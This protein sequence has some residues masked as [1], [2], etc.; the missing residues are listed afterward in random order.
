MSKIGILVVDDEPSL[1][2]FLSILLEKDGYAVFTAA[3]GAEALAVLRSEVID[4]VITDIQMDGMSGLEL[5]S[6]IRAQSPE[7]VVLAITAFGSSEI[8]IEAMKCG[9]YDYINKPFQVDEIRI[10]VTKALENIKLREENLHLRKELQSRSQLKDIVGTSEAM[11]RVYQ[12]ITRVA[13]LDST[14]LITGESGTGK[15]LV[16]RAIHFW[17][18]RK[19]SPFISVNCGALPETLLE[20]ELFGHQKGSFT[21]AVAQKRG[22]L[23]TAEGGTF[24][25][26]EIGD[27]PSLIQVKLLQA[28]QLKSFK[29][30]GG[31]TDINVDVRFIAATNR[32]LEQAVQEKLFR[33]DLYYRLNV[34]PIHLPPLRER[35]EDIPLLVGHF[36][37]RFSDKCG[38]PVKTLS[39][40]A[41]EKL[42]SY[43][44]PG[45][46]RELENVIERAVALCSGEVIEAESI[47]LGQAQ[48]PGSST[49]AVPALG[50][51]GLDLEAHLQAVER[52]LILQAL[53][54]AG[55][56]KTEA[57]RLLGLSFR[58]LRYRAE[59]LGL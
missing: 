49:P 16:A 51:G 12:I 21:G 18:R 15:E 31:N 14:V 46:A 7:I 11:Q 35:R 43:S 54:F 20:S 33:E 36:L 6:R 57:A 24:F 25:L 53:E 34:I 38:A 10:I 32:D 47:S 58:S 37:K 42:L 19:R 26:D 3:S 39:P 9:A 45:N 52:S 5:V 27:T 28:I 1:R 56:S 48:R 44:W 8:A 4:L 13:D 17:G 59:K 41:Q 23:E 55:G 22:L 40:A 50:E 29:R 2:E 30:I